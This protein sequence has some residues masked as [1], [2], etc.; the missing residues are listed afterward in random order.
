M[1]ITPCLPAIFAIMLV[2]T[3]SLAAGDRNL[4]APRVPADQLESARALH[5]PLSASPDVIEKGKALYE[6]KGAC[7]NC[8]GARGLGDG[9]AAKNLNPSPRN[10]HHRGFWRHRTDG[11]IFWVIKHGLPGTAMMGFGSQ[12]SDEEIWTVIR[13]LR[14]F[15]GGHESRGGMGRRGPM[16]GRGMEERG[17]CDEPGAER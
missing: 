16:G 3:T 11:E 9:P 2:P 17:C 13:Y 6:G 4:M 7:V 10:F 12:L 14:T 8:H 15:A 5:N 1:K